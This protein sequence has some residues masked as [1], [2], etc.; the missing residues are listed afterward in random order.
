MRVGSRLLF[1]LMISPFGFPA[2]ADDAPTD[3][4]WVDREACDIFGG[5]QDTVAGKFLCIFTDQVR[6][7]G[8]ATPLVAQDV[9]TQIVEASSD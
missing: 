8:G 7:A 9:G 1:A 3:Y 6:R 2:Q 4:D 5:T